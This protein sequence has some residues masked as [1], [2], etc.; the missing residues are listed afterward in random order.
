M[1]NTA[2]TASLTKKELA[3]LAKIRANR[4]GSS[5]D[6]EPIGLDKNLKTPKQL[7]EDLEQYSRDL[8]TDW[9]R[10]SFQDMNNAIG[11]FLQDSLDTVQIAVD[12]LKPVISFVATALEILAQFAGLA[13]DLIS[14][15][16]GAAILLLEGIVDIFQ[17]TRLAELHYIPTNKKML[18][19]TDKVL[20]IIADSYDDKADADR[21][22]S[23]STSDTHLFVGFLPAFPNYGR[24]I[25][26]LKEMGKLFDFN[27]DGLKVKDFKPE[28][29]PNN[30]YETGTSAYP[31]WNALALSDF[32][33]VA[34]ISRTL[35]GVIAGLKT[36]QKKTDAVLAL[37]RQVEQ[38][39]INIEAK[40]RQILDVL[41]ALANLSL[42]P[43]NTLTIFGPSDIKGVQASIRS[44]TSLD[45]YPLERTQSD[46]CAAICLHFTLGTGRALDFVKALFAIKD[47]AVAQFEEIQEDEIADITKQ[48][49]T[50]AVTSNSANQ[51]L[52]IIWRG[53][54]NG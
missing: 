28:D 49:K 31:D 23:R 18:K 26:V 8:Q 54:N 50:L 3:Q 46:Y 47:K 20:N 30:L 25:E 27:T 7:L 35:D 17:T 13:I 53:T 44:A 9:N 24:L 29:Y 36:T 38:R 52:N 40:L 1:S 37:V 11:E 34:K 45:T 14:D 42:L 15:A 48:S 32:S 5:E 4:F 43:I 6:F 51:Q 39:L 21:P 22:I 41:E 12:T 33:F 2:Y 16:F 10:F 19:S